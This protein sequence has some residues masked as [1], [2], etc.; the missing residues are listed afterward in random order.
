MSI[1][2]VLVSSSCCPASRGGL[3]LLGIRTAERTM[4]PVSTAE[5]KAGRLP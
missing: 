5:E 4:D 3:F 2:P 1:N